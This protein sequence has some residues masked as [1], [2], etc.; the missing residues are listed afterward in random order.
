MI[1]G[2]GQISRAEHLPS[3]IASMLGKEIREGRLLPGVK[4]PSENELAKTFG[5]SRSV[6]REAIAQL[7]SDGVV[8]TR[9]GV[10]AFVIEP[11]KWVSLRIDAI[12]LIDHE[13]LRSLFELR[14]PLEVVAAEL[15]AERRTDQQMEAIDAALRDMNGAGKW[16]DQGVD[17]DLRFHHAV[18]EAANSGYYPVFLGYIADK[19]STAIKSA[20]N[21]A[22][23]EEIVEITI[24]EHTR[25]R[26]AIAE[27]NV[28]A[29][30]RAMREHL[31]GARA[32]LDLRSYE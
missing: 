29:A 31:L 18:A 2:L 15:A 21:K 32:R 12:S 30:N 6:V 11:D 13:A 27:Q 26:D 7:R 22:V 5:V 24:A 28:A 25:I 14:E 4:L 8:E 1:S 10:G 3:R 17:A 20:R 16:T 23:L 19:I 9:Q